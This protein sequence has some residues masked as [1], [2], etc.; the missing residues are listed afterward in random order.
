[1][2][3]FNQSSARRALLLL[4]TALLAGAVGCFKSSAPCPVMSL[5]VTPN[6]LVIVRNTSRQMA[7]TG[8]DYKGNVV[9][10]T[11]AWSIV[12]GG[13]TIGST[14][15]FTAGAPLGTFANTVQATN[16]GMKAFGTVTVIANPGPLASITVT[17]NPASVE[18]NLTQQ[19]VATG[20]DANGNDVVIVPTWSVVAGGGAISGS[21]NFTAGAA[22][23]AFPNTVKATSGAVSGLATVNVTA[24]PGPGT[25]LLGSAGTFAVLGGSTV[26]N[27]G[28]TTT[29][30]GDVGVSPG[31]AIVGIPVGQPTNGSIHSADAPAATAQS[32][33]TT[34]YNDLAGRAC[35]TNLTSQDLGGMTLAPG[36]YCFNSSAA[37]TGTLTL[38]GQ[39]NSSSVF[40]IQTGS[41]LT[42]ASN[43]A[44]TLIGGALARNVYWK[45]ASSA[46]LGSGTAFKGNIVA[47]QSVTLN[48][49]ATL[50]GRA[51]A[52]N[53]AVTL[54]SNA[55][56]LP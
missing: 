27:T 15:I 51:L 41:T 11:A 50:Q 35:G 32:N 55:I 29:I 47:L 37:L 3:Q 21:G 30:S 36:V 26:T 52:R 25:G 48:T 24:V 19:F 44:V 17:P 49:G 53:G 46:T 13:G 2:I 1:M 9:S 20:K 56:T 40:I 38:D 43:A 12:A 33:L 4:S 16:G 31:A 23:G 45:V 28:A 42:T 8:L 7:A 6:P 5:T 14:G 10:N 39:G 54:D 18:V 22:T 34:A